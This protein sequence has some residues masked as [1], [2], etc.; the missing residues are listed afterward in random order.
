VLVRV[1]DVND[2]GCERGDGADKDFGFG[3]ED[4]NDRAFGIDLLVEPEEAPANADGLVIFLVAGPGSK[5]VEEVSSEEAIEGISAA[6]SSSGV[7][8]ESLRFP[9]DVVEVNVQL[10]SS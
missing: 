10:S 7:M 6:I 8:A 1:L 2:L 3:S 9:A 4:G 5:L